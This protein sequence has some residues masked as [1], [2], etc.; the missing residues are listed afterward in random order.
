MKK[1]APKGPPLSPWQVS[2]PCPPPQIAFLVRKKFRNPFCQNLL[3]QDWVSCI[4]IPTHCSFRAPTSEENNYF[5]VMFKIFKPFSV[6]PHPLMIQ[7][8]AGSMTKFLGGRQAGRTNSVSSKGLSRIIKAMSFS[9]LT[10][11]FGT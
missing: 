10:T 9:F 6:F 2:A 7:L 5:Q 11:P 8:A 3:L 1:L 4:G